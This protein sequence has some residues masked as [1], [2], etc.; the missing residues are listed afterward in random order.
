MPPDCSLADWLYHFLL[1]KQRAS[2]APQGG[3]IALIS[4]P[5][6]IFRSTALALS[7]ARYRSR[8][9]DEN[10]GG[11]HRHRRP[12]PLR[13]LALSLSLPRSPLATRLRRTRGTTSAV[14]QPPRGGGGPPPLPPKTPPR[15]F[16][17]ATQASGS[18]G[19]G[20]RASVAGPPHDRAPSQRR[21]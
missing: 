2:A 9:R 16:L 13:S 19:L 17:L 8:A 11:S 5:R 10:L 15:H 21:P 14:A 12:P 1:S 20:F 18:R 3:H 4:P 7:T 6:P